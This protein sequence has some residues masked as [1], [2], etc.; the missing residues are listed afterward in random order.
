[1]GCWFIFKLCPIHLYETLW[2]S[3][4]NAEIKN[5]NVNVSGSGR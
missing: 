3:F 1:M 5:K 2:V 4:I